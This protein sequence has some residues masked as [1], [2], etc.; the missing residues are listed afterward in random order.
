MGS[1]LTISLGNGIRYIQ[2]MIISPEAII[3]YV[4]PTEM[5]EIPT[6][7][8]SNGGEKA[9]DAIANRKR[10]RGWPGNTKGHPMRDLLTIAA[11][12]PDKNDSLR[13]I[14]DPGLLMDVYSDINDDN[15][16]VG[17]AR[18]RAT[19]SIV[20]KRF[21]QLD[22]TPEVA[23]DS[24]TDLLE[25]LREMTKIKDL[26]WGQAIILYRKRVG[27]SEFR[28]GAVAPEQKSPTPEPQPPTEK[29]TQRDHY[30]ILP[31][32]Y[33]PVRRVVD[34]SK[35]IY[36]RRKRKTKRKQTVK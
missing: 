9:R 16:S 15:L 35:I 12:T 26:T 28:K 11:F 24:D 23:T 18:A 17:G 2:R 31:D 34:P 3:G 6:T 8:S 1:G 33:I 7:S 32:R 27:L 10:H 19:I 30:P 14:S 13:S 4:N 22:Q 25:K 29:H 20:M 36:E 5:E 21:R